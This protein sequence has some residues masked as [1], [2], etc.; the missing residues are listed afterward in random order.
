MRARM[1]A[2]V[3]IAAQRDPK[4]RV[5]TIEWLDP[6]MT[7]GNWMPSLIRMAGG[8]DVLGADGKHSS[9][10]SW[11]DLVA[12]DPDVILVFPCGFRIADSLR[13][14]HLLT[15]RQEWPTLRAVRAG[16]VYVCDGNQYF[17]RPGPR[18]A[19][20]LEII[21]EILHPDVF[22]FGRQGEGWQRCAD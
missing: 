15:E 19:E 8:I 1:E 21:A 13:D 10:I 14:W 5:V 22:R 4:P 3:R 6:L 17:N 16:Q 18:L 11:D 12:S 20:S 9:W 7:A 2:I